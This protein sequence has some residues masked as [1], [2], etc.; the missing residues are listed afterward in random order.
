[1]NYP[2][3]YYLNF[4][5]NFLYH[6]FFHIINFISLF[7]LIYLLMSDSLLNLITCFRIRSRIRISFLRVLLNQGLSLFLTVIVLVGIHSFDNR[8]GLGGPV[9]KVVGLPVQLLAYHLCVASSRP[10]LETQK[11]GYGV[12]SRRQHPISETNQPRTYI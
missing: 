2:I 5:Q 10:A 8:R 9:V 11:N 4:S 7:F 6:F 3:K 1:M 12:M